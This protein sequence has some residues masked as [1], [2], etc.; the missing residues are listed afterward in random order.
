MLELYRQAVAVGWLTASQANEQNFLAAG[1]RAK[2]QAGNPV[3][4]FV[5]IVRRGLWDYITQ[6]QETQAVQAL[7]R[8]RE[9]RTVTESSADVR[10]L[11]LGL[12]NS[13]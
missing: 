9:K 4:I 12:Q 1:V 3:R 8:W 2:R 13:F 7:K 6:E 11:V 5:G 10:R